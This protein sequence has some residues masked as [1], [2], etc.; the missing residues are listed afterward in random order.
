MER[1]WLLSICTERILL[2]LACFVYFLY[3]CCFPCFVFGYLFVWCLLIWD[4]FLFA[5]VVSVF[6]V[7]LCLCI[8]FMLNGTTHVGGSAVS[9]FGWHVY[10]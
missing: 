10:F 7:W 5:C 1:G 4:S 9:V 8:I 6:F 2:C 3:V